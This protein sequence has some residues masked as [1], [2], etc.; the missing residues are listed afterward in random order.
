MNT[1]SN[2]NLEE[3]SEAFLPPDDGMEEPDATRTEDIPLLQSNQP[4]SQYT[5]PE[6][7]TVSNLQFISKM[8]LFI[9]TLV[10]QYLNLT[11]F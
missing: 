2:Q 1:D 11:V 7:Q 3:G 9:R 4:T 5:N 10:N 8:T 6:P